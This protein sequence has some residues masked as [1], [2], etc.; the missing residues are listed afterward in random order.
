[1]VLLFATLALGEVL[2]MESSKPKDL[3]DLGYRHDLGNLR[4]CHNI[5]MPMM[6]DDDQIS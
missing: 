4:I 2:E 3:D 1:M 5:V 6:L